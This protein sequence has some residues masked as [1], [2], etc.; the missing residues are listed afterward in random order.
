MPAQH[1]PLAKNTRSQRHQA[2]LTPTARAPLDCT[3]SVHQLSEALDRGPSMEGAAPSRRGGGPK[4]IFGEAEDEEGEESE[5]TEVAASL[6]GAPEDSEAASLAKY[7]QPLVSQVEQNFHKMMEQ[8]TQFMGKLTQ[9][10]TTRD[11]SKATSFNTS[12]M[13]AHD[14][15][16]GTQAHKLR[17]FIQSCQLIFHNYPA[18]FFFDRKK[19]RIGIKIIE[20]FGSHPGTFDTL[21]ELLDITLELDTRFH[22]RQKGKGGNQEKK[23][24]VTRSNA[25]IPPQDSSSKRPQYK[26]NKKGKKS[27]VFKD[28]PHASLL[29]KENKLIG[30]EKERRTKKGLCTYCGGKHPIEKCFKRPKSKPGLSKGFPSKQGKS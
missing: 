16:D 14:S 20:S 26:R 1:S 4:S 18:K 19:N 3:P 11:N 23:P 22:E 29:N 27:Q 13:K 2:A 15:F 5:E 21:Q 7:N 9:S 10:V 17:G 30:S 8:I 28:K 25:S 6:A 12:S 24:P